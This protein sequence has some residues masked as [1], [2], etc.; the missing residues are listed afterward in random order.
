M[1]IFNLMVIVFTVLAC[2][3]AKENQVSTSANTLTAAE[4]RAGWQLIFDGKT[5]N[6]WHAYGKKSVG[7]GWNID[8]NALHLDPAKKAA[9]NPTSEDLMTAEEYD[10]FHLKLDWKISPNGNSGIIFNVNEDVAKYAAPWLTGPEMQ[11]VDN[12]G[13]PD[14]RII[15]HQAG[16]LYDLVSVSKKTVKPVGEW[17][18]IEIISNKGKLDF[19]MNGE[20][21]VNTT[22]W[23]A[24]WKNMLAN[25]KFKD[26]KDFGVYK[27]G[28]IA[29]QDHGDHVWYRNIKIRKL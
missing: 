11:V 29:L 27:K 24:S 19:Y 25:S 10:N 18:A 12:E 4:K 16:D 22:M 21:V 7:Q 6:G 26:Y 14:G 23:N 3:T 13:H 1:K 20:H 5:L 17:N 15:K 2:S 28:R 8:G 9:M